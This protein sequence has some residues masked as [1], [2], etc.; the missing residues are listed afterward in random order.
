MGSPTLTRA[1]FERRWQ[2]TQDAMRD[3]SL[4]LI[5]AYGDDHAVFGPAN[6]RYLAN[7][8]VHFEPACVVM[9]LSGEPILATGP[10]F[11]A[12]AEIVG[13]IDTVV[14]INEFGVPGEEYPYLEIHSLAQVIDRIAEVKPQRVGVAGFD[15]MSVDTWERLRPAVAQAE[16][17]RVDDVFTR[18]RKYKSAEEIEVLR[19]AFTLTQHAMDALVEACRAGAYEFELAAAAEYAMR[20]RGAEGLAIDTIVASG[21]ENSRPII[22]RTGRRQLQKGEPILVTLAP[23]YEGYSAPI[24]RLVHLGEPSPELRKAADAA[25]EAQRRA[26]EALSPGI[27]CQE[28]DRAARGYLQERGYGQYCAYG[29]AHSVGVQEFEPPFFGPSSDE[30][31]EPSMVVSVDIPMFFGPWGGFRLEDS[32]VVTEK[33]AEPLTQVQQGMIVLP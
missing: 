2:A 13:S 28:V 20:S 19:Y 30:V 3:A 7:F 14:A 25:R 10:E 17:V 21:R 24:G 22:G 15:Q 16:I 5:L 4:D 31:V 9:S 1:E 32:F 23:R 12:H 26:V 29:V 33:G 8:P 11:A 18:L 6:V 27:S